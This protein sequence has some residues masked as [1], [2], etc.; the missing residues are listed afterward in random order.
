MQRC[1][2]RALWRLTT[3]AVQATLRVKTNPAAPERL[4]ESDLEAVSGVDEK[5]PPRNYNEGRSRWSP[6]HFFFHSPMRRVTHCLVPVAEFLQMVLTGKT[7]APPGSVCVDALSAKVCKLVGKLK[8]CGPELCNHWAMTATSKPSECLLNPKYMH[9]NCRK[10]CRGCSN[11][12][13]SYYESAEVK[14]LTETRKQI[15]YAERGAGKFQHDAKKK[16][17][18]EYAGPII[19]GVRDHDP[20]NCRNCDEKCRQKRDSKCTKHALVLLD[21]GIDSEVHQKITHT[22]RDTDMTNWGGNGHYMPGSTAKA[23]GT[24]AHD[25]AHA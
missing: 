24:S 4:Q 23:P 19:Q 20:N 7:W 6:R 11:S 9:E 13:T 1:P 15:V 3:R 21:L 17:Q 5:K 8:K 2:P 25:D 16:S 14:R 18:I 12:G 22:D 10:S